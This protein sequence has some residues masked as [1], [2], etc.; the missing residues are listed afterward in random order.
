[1]A[2][3]TRTRDNSATKKIYDEYIDL[4]S[5]DSDDDKIL[6]SVLVDELEEEE[7]PMFAEKEETNAR[8]C[9]VLCNINT[10]Y[11]YAHFS[12]INEVGDGWTGENT[13]KTLPVN[14]GSFGVCNLTTEEQQDELSLF[15]K[16]IP[17]EF[18]YTLVE[19]TNIYIAEKARNIIKKLHFSIPTVFR[20]L[21]SLQR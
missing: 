13:L 10:S 1:M 16:Y 9:R 7:L 8:Y 15:F 4:E 3:H 14:H 17:M 2:Y 18:F 5:Y 21:L 6:P 12:D 20:G 19:Q 11:S